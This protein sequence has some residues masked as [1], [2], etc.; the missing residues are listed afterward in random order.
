MS[1][2]IKIGLLPLYVALYDDCMP[3]MRQSIEAYYHHIAA[4]LGE[5]GMDVITAPVC[6]V[7]DEFE[8]A[9]QHFETSQAEA[10]I[11]LHLAYSPSLES[12]QALVRTKLPIIVLDTTPDACFDTKADSNRIMYNHGIHGVQDMCNRLCRNRKPFVIYAGHA[13]TSDVIERIAKAAEIAAI[14]T[15]LIHSKVGLIGGT[16]QW[17]GRYCS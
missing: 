7:Q 13:D 4:M 11:T 5:H 15:K 9:I 3:E 16:V 1:K 6:R 17:H 2:S 12:E 14:Y 10:M 8:S